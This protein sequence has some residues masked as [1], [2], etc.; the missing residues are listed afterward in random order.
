[1]R[2]KLRNEPNL[3]WMLLSGN[4]DVVL[5][6]DEESA[7]VL[8][9]DEESVVFQLDEDSSEQEEGAATHKRKL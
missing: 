6:S 5:Q 8:Q 7:A 3:I 1:L 2:C 4:Q 9:S